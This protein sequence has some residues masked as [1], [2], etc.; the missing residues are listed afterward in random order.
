MTFYL[1]GAGAYCIFLLFKKFSDKECS[2]TD[3]ASWLVI[4]IAVTLWMI[5][6]PLSVVEL[7]TK[8]KRQKQLDD[9]LTN[10]HSSLNLQTTQIQQQ[11]FES[12]AISQLNPSNS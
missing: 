4:A 2:E 6:I 1:S 10:T 11:E 12:Q 9:I 7:R 5:V 8:A 3:P